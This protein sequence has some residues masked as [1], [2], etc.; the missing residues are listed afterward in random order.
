MTI[1]FVLSNICSIFENAMGKESYRKLFLLQNFLVYFWR[2]KG[3]LEALE[4]SQ[5]NCRGY[6]TLKN[7]ISCRYEVQN[8][9]YPSKGNPKRM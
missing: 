6:M 7:N 9:K 8:L 4:G 2:P 1:D 5:C 3:L